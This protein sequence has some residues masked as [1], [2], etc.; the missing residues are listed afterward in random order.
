MDGIAI[1]EK[2]PVASCTLGELTDFLIRRISGHP[3]F[4]LRLRAEIQKEVPAELFPIE[5][6]EIRESEAPKSERIKE[7]IAVGLTEMAKHFKVCKSTI[8]VWKK[9]F[10]AP[11]ITKNGRFIT[12]DIQKANELYKAWKMSETGHS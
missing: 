5:Q 7:G 4:Q 8:K 10:L 6:E 9:G 3:D 12:M 2:T 1:N 11:A